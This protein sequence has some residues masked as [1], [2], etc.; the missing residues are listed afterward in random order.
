MLFRNTKSQSSFL[1][2]VNFI[3]DISLINNPITT[4]YYKIRNY[5]LI[6]SEKCFNHGQVFKRV[7]WRLCNP[8]KIEYEKKVSNQFC[9]VCDKHG[10]LYEYAGLGVYHADKW[11]FFNRYIWSDKLNYH[12]TS[13]TCEDR[14]FEPY[15]IY[16]AS[17]G[18]EG[19]AMCAG[20]CGSTY[21][22]KTNKPV[23]QIANF[24]GV[25]YV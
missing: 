23:R 18:E 20:E 17:G 21:N 24:W 12:Y 5:E 25:Y 4:L 8:L 6:L 9:A 3:K 10:L 14:L 22:E 1:G 19:S 16:L 11:R 2:A 7:Q 13:T 15:E